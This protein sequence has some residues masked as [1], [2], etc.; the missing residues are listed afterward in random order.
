MTM[1]GIDVS[2][3]Q[4]AIDWAKL[5]AEGVGFA[6][7]KVAEADDYVNPYYRQQVE[8]ARA[9]GIL[10]GHYFYAQPDQ[11]TVG[12]QVAHFMAHL[13]RRAGEPVALD[14]EEGT[15][16]LAQ[17]ALV[18]LRQVE[19]AIGAKPLLYTYP[20]FMDQH[21]LHDAA[22]AQ[23]P[24]W[25]AAYTG[26][27]AWPTPPAPW[28]DVAVWQWTADGRLSGIPDALVDLNRFPGDAG[29]WKL[30]AGVGEVI[31]RIEPAN[32]LQAWF[33]AH[34]RVA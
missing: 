23:Y 16:N 21:G 4:P 12:P 31:G 17:W 11:T 9:H 26:S 22:L 3:H 30:L 18:W 19:L 10:V 29:A 25:Y 32:R 27:T 14:L 7:V 24:L 28:S 2:S 6:F 20:Y 34:G 8:G 13:D 15:G 1:L 33:K 5:A